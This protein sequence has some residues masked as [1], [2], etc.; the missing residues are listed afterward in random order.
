M[1]ISNP[2][3]L[4]EQL[5]GRTLSDVVT[6]TTRAASFPIAKAI[7]LN[8]ANAVGG[9]VAVKL[10]TAA[11]A[12][13]PAAI[14]TVAG[15]GLLGTVG[16]L[17][18]DG[19][20]T[21]VRLVPAIVGAGLGVVTSTVNAVTLTGLAS[22]RAVLN[23][24]MAALSLNPLAVVNAAALGVVRVAGVVEQTTIGAPALAF[25]SPQPDAAVARRTPSILT[26]I[27]NGR[28]QIA[29]AIFPTAVR[30]Q[31]VTASAATT[32]VT[33]AASTTHKKAST[34]KA[35]TAAKHAKKK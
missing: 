31:A 15:G 16:N 33:A 21:T 18:L 35:T 2:I 32:A 4:G 26:S 22:V 10:D 12:S 29:N 14:G 24:G 20:D 19:V 25:T 3:A 5:A 6:Q 13:S 9:R 11:A 8:V 23:V 7:V 1:Q 34:T 28:Q 17:V 30:A 27:L